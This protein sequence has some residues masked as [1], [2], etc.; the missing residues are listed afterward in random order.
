MEFV[1]TVRLTNLGSEDEGCFHREDHV[2]E[3]RQARGCKFAESPYL[4]H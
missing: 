3:V 1:I 4:A 2:V